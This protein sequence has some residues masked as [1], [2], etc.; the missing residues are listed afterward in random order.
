MD[1]LSVAFPRLG[2]RMLVVGSSM[3]AGH[4]TAA[5]V[6]AREAIAAGAQ[7]RVVDY[8]ELPHGPQ[9]AFIR[10]LYRV[11]VTRTPWLYDVIMRAW[12]RHPRLFERL[13]AIGQGGYIRGLQ[14]E[15]ATFE[16]DVIVSTYNLAGQLLG[17]L[18]A[19]GRLTTTVIAYVTDAGAHPYWVSDGAD[20]HLA[21][22]QE[23]AD[24]LRAMGAPEVDV[25]AP[26]V[27]EPSPLTRD[28][29]RGRLGLSLQARI[30]L[31]NGGS[32]GVGAVADAARCVGATGAEVHV[33]CG[34]VSRLAKA[35]AAL[36]HCHAVGWTEHVDTWIKAADVVVDSAGG[37]T[38]WESIVAGRPLIVHRP[39]AGHGRL[40][41]TTLEAMGLAT[42]TD[43]EEQLAAAA[44]HATAPH[45][46]AV[47]DACDVTQLLLSAA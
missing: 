38:G 43:S 26:L 23:T 2:T 5:R 11:M 15:I 19:S 36:P 8:L 22:L 24:Q 41:A 14:R 39:L 34:N 21:P 42:V 16:P 37:A 40:N 25:V 31:V 12:M 45:N 13:S 27:P 35:V 44:W 6:L 18:K 46:D 47:V 30:V 10:S 32:W 4:M 28:E 17:R 1:T 33:L 7:A 9:G 3:G 29:A 20:L